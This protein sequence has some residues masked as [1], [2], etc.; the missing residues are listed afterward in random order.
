MFNSIAIPFN[1]RWLVEY[2]LCGLPFWSLLWSELIIPMD[3]HYQEMRDLSIA[4]I[5]E[6]GWVR[7]ELR[8]YPWENR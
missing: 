3:H 6:A 2:E 8:M 4:V 1:E 5:A 7:D